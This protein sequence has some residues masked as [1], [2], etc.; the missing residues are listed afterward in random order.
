M[1]TFHGLSRSESAVT[2]L[3]A[4][5]FV[6]RVFS[7]GELWFGST[8]LNAKRFKEIVELKREILKFPLGFLF[9]LINFYF[10]DCR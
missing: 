4:V 7:G 1:L 6:M 3:N 2:E 10:S 8:P 5:L 9:F